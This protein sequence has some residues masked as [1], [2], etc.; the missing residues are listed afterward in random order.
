MAVFLCLY[1]GREGVDVVE[2]VIGG[3]CYKNCFLS[4]VVVCTVGAVDFTA[5][6][7]VCRIDDAD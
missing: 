2:N 1:C 6:V 3:A 4:D 7:V 5:D